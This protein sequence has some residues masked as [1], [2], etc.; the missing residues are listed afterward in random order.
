VAGLIVGGVIAAPL[1]GYVTRILPQ[2]I[3]MALVGV[4]ITALSVH[5]TLRL[6]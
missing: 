2:Q 1:A 4:L 5:Q 3:L 6:L